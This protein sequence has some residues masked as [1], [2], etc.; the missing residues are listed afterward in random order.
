MRNYKTFRIQT[1]SDNVRLGDPVAVITG[2]MA[3]LTSLFP[4]IFGGGR[5]KLT[6]AHWIELM[7]GN[8]SWTTALRTYLAG[9]IHYDN[10]LEN[11][12]E[13]TKYF[14]HENQAQICKEMNLQNYPGQYSNECFTRF[15]QILRE[16]TY[17]GGTSPVGQIPGGYGTINWASVIPFAIGG[18]VLI[19]L[20]KNKKR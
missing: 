5:T 19:A 1:L 20:F 15:L 16:E 3:L 11:I 2:G 10:N 12:Q 6:R 8:G 17:T 13:Y 7:P 14:V 9:A 18:I 4:N